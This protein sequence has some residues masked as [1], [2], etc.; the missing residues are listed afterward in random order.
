MERYELFNLLE[1]LVETLGE[2][3]VLSEIA[4]GLSVDELEFQLND[5]VR[6]YD[7]EENV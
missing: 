4:K 7:L 2:E 3:T 5:I 1:S 6:L